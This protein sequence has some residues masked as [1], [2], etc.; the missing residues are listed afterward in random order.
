MRTYVTILLFALSL[1]VSAQISSKNGRAEKFFH[2]TEVN[3][4]KVKPKNGKV[5]AVFPY[6]NH[7]ERTVVF[8]KHVTSCGCTKVV[9]S[10]EPVRPGGKGQIVVTIDKPVFK[11]YF[12]K[13]VMVYS[14]GLSPTILKIKGTFIN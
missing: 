8:K 2:T 3:L 9:Y 14:I 13:S 1:T 5:T 12:A 11:G 7:T 10:K 6:T 4:G